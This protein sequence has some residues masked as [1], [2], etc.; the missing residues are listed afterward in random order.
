MVLTSLCRCSSSDCDDWH[1]DLSLLLPGSFQ[2]S[3]QLDDGSERLLVVIEIATDVVGMLMWQLWPLLQLVNLAVLVLAIIGIVAAAQ[4]KEK[5]LP[6]VGQFS[7][8]FPI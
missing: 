4:S 1:V 6:L 8:Y 3:L 5:E 2:L 7:S